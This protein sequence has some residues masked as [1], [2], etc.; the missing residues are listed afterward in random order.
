[1][2]TTAPTPTERSLRQSSASFMQLSLE[3]IMLGN[4]LMVLLGAQL[5]AAVGVLAMCIFI[6]R[7]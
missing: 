1:M 4:I 3:L 5:G 6:N 7:K 2:A